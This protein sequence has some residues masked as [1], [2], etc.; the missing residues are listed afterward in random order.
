M[1]IR[2]RGADPELVKALRHIALDEGMAHTRG[3]VPVN[4][5]HVVSR[6]VFADLVEL[7][8]LA[9]EYRMVFARELLIDEPVRDDPDLPDLLH[10][11][12]GINRHQGGW[13]VVDS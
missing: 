5:P 12:F 10:Q 3:H 13:L 6:D 11:L 7:H 8:S 9:L 4:G 1:D 2:V